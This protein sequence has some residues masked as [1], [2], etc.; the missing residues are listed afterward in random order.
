MNSL[1][2][3]VILF[4]AFLVVVMPSEAR[5]ATGQTDFPPAVARAVTHYADVLSRVTAAN[6][7]QELEQLFAASRAL[8]AALLR[9]VDDNV[10]I[11]QLSV[12]QFDYL[13]AHTRGVI[14]GREEVLIV[15]PD[16]SFFLTLAR[17]YGTRADVDFAE[18][19]A[20]TYL[21]TAW[22]SYLWQ[23]TDVTACTAFG[24][25]ELVARYAQWLSFREI[26]PRAY[27]SEVLHELSEIESQVATSN[28]ACGS[29]ADVLAELGEFAAAFPAVASRLGVNERVAAIHAGKS[30]F[31]FNC[32][33]G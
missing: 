14:I 32:S 7:R 21:D 2:A 8:K 23:E 9:R 4:P 26:H 19:Y 15:E 12:E 16:A 11:E 27:Q 33:P 24:A 18:A 31:T 30:T 20:A 13:L 25:G 6:R 29:R 1:R 3:A 10:I 28:C 17:M 5:C 22:P